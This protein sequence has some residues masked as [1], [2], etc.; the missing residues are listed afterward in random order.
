[1]IQDKKLLPILGVSLL[2][3]LILLSMNP[4]S[5]ES[6]Y[7]Q[8]AD[9][10]TIVNIPNFFNVLSNLPFLIVG[11][12]G[13]RLMLAGELNL[14]DAHL[15]K[16][17]L[18]FFMGVLLTGLGSVYYHYRPDNS[19][20]LWDRLP[21]TISFMA[22][23]C[24]IVGECISITLAK[25][26]LLP[27]L[28]LGIASVFYWHITESHGQGDLRPYILIQFLPIAL[29]PLILWQYDGKQKGC[30]YVWLVLGAYFLAKVAES[31]DAGIYQNT[32]IIS[33]HSLKHLLAGFGTYIV[34]ATLKARPNG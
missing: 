10:R 34:Y 28:A 12:L 8:F 11:F 5:Q 7:H 9:S 14:R 22:F 16:A 27:L 19:S 13:I 21:I 30:Q 18:L 2:A 4:I 3:A 26:L 23:F 32:H 1:M 17:Y 25:R 29:I 31:L 15:N 6:G 20:L 24:A 33:G